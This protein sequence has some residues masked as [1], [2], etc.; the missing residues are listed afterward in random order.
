MFNGTLV[1]FFLIL[2]RIG[3]FVLTSPIFSWKV[4]PV[5][6]KMAIVLVLSA[7]FA[8]LTPNPYQGQSPDLLL[9]TL[10]T[11]QEAVYGL[12]MG[13]IA[14]SLFAVIR[15]AGRF[16]ERQ[17]GLTMAKILDPFTGEQSQPVGMIL[18][19]MFILLLFN[20]EAHHLLLGILSRSY[21]IYPA[22][23][24][25]AISRLFESVLIS[26]SVMLTLML[27]MAAP[28]LAVFLLL[29]VVLGFMARVAPETNILF[30]SLPIRVGVGLLIV[31]IFIPFVNEYI[32]QFAFW[33]NRLIPF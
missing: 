12:A 23:Q 7:F 9:I 33:L 27:Q 17:M 1:S 22:G 10:L 19:I 26:G 14:F 15:Q 3:A 32:S 16:L 31:R 5:R 20:T 25:P 2:T 8:V 28:M 11:A 24:I 29:M 13:L 4:L 21:E 18:E 30:L 6:S